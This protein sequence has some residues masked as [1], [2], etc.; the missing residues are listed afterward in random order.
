MDHVLIKRICETL[1]N[2]KRVDAVVDSLFT[3]LISK[4]Y[5][6]IVVSS[7][8]VVVVVLLMLYMCFNVQQ[9]KSNTIL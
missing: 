2:D 8:T 6:F 3:K 7:L 5:P 4:L 1:T 9:I